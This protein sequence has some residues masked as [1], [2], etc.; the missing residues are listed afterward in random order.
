MEANDGFYR[1]PFLLVDDLAGV[2][3]G[4]LIL[5]NQHP[6]WICQ[7]L[8]ILCCLPQTD[9]SITGNSHAGPP[10]MPF[11]LIV[12]YHHV[13]FRYLKRGG[14]EA[15]QKMRWDPR[16]PSS[17]DAACKVAEPTLLCRVTWAGIRPSVPLFRPVRNHLACHETHVFRFHSYLYVPS[18]IYLVHA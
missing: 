6:F 5:G 11:I 10:S 15:V 9:T 17:F 16:E 1:C 18:L 4:L 8:P 12:R 14:V 2:R 7:T 13:V 3:V